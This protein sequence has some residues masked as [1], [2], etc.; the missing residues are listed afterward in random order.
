M[1]LRQDSWGQDSSNLNNSIVVANRI[2]VGGIRQARQHRSHDC[3][4]A[5]G[6]A[7]DLGG[8]SARRGEK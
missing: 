3:V 5:S 7:S 8:E 4:C 1:M 2:V 6:E